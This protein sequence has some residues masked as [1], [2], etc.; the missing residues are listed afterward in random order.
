MGVML[1]CD[2]SEVC[3][4]TKPHNLSRQPDNSWL[5][6]TCEIEL[7]HPE[8]HEQLISF[9]CEKHGVVTWVRP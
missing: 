9:D 8:V 7:D 5:C 2:C 1:E 4:W 6:S 3:G